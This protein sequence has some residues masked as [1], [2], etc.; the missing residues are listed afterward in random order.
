MA[1]K[2]QRTRK[3]KAPAIHR[4]SRSFG[5]YVGINLVEDVASPDGSMDLISA[6]SGETSGAMPLLLVD[7]VAWGFLNL[8]APSARLAR[9]LAGSAPAE[10]TARFTG[11]A[12]ARASRCV[13][14]DVASAVCCATECCAEGRLLGYCGSPFICHAGTTITEK[15]SSSRAASANVRTMCCVAAERFFRISAA[16]EPI[17]NRSVDFTTVSKMIA[18]DERACM[19]IVPPA[20][21]F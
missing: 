19:L 2:R 14:G 4:P 21:L 16:P 15:G 20:A 6:G 13:N 7:A 8:A 18:D 5:T 17:A 12:A 1:F 11:A 3:N 9:K 10:T